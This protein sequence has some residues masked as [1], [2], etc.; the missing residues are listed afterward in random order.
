M[1]R[2]FK[3]YFDMSEAFWFS[4]ADSSFEPIIDFEALNDNEIS[5]TKIDLSDEKDD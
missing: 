4:I 1:F 5:L 3:N 2:F